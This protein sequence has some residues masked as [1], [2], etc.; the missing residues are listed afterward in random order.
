M[1]KYIYIHACK[2]FFCIATITCNKSNSKHITFFFFFTVIIG[3]HPLSSSKAQYLDVTAP[4]PIL[5]SDFF[6]FVST[7]DTG[8]NIIL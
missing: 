2:Y 5:N 7:Y 4:L 1:V 3:K 6:S 8:K